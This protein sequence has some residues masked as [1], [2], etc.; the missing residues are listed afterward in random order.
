MLDQDQGGSQA[1]PI[2]QLKG[3]RVEFQTKDGP[4]VGVEDVSF[5]INPGETVCV[6]G[7]SGSG[8]STLAKTLI[9]L[10]EPSEGA[11]I[12]NE[13]DFLGLNGADLVRARKN[14]QMIFQD[15]FGSLNPSQS[16][17]FMVT[18]GL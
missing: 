9:R 17:G 3:L 8:K 5:D 10:E 7:E 18:R 14:I 16:V 2:A 1:Q 4:V 12:I 11:V 6:V 13:Q 15:P